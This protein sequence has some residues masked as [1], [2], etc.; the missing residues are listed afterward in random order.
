MAVKVFYANLSNM[1]V[2]KNNIAYID[3]ANL[4][5]SITRL[6]WCLDYGRF[7][8]WLR[9]K[10]DVQTAY[11]FIGLIPKYKNLYNYF[12][13]HLKPYSYVQT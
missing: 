1:I 11:L 8:V 5:N 9:E 6:K 12:I 3:A 10:Y 2:K 7:R 13:S 4:H